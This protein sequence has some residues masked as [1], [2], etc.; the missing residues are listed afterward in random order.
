MAKRKKEISEFGE[1]LEQVI[2]EAGMFKSD[3]YAVPDG[4]GDYN[5]ASVAIP[6]D[7]ANVT[8]QYCR[9]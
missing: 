7:G 2:K 1:Y 8:D 9:F 5:F 4:E 6:L 3:F